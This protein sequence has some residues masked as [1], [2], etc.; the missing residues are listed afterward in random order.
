MKWFTH[1][2]V[3]LVLAA[4]MLLLRSMFHYDQIA[5]EAGD[6]ALIVNSAWFE[7]MLDWEHR[8]EKFAHHGGPSFTYRH[9]DS[10]TP[11]GEWVMGDRFQ[12]QSFFDAPWAWTRYVAFPHWFL[13][14]MLL[15][16]PVSRWGV[17]MYRKRGQPEGFPVTAK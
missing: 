10:A 5:I 16:V 4:T 15:S 3:I 6:H 1:V 7:V 17:S 8:T 2:S 12:Y 14:V 13:I 11:R 9:A